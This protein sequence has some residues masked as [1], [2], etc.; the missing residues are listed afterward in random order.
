MQA[1][2]GGSHVDMD[3]RE[4]G[5]PGKPR[6]SA[7]QPHVG[8][9]LS[10]FFLTCAVYFLLWSPEN[11]PSWVGALIKCLPVL[12][13]VV[14]LW[15]VYPGGSYSLLLQGALLCSAV[16]DSCLVWP[17]AFLHG[18]AAFAVAHLLY[19]WAFGLTPLKPGLLLPLLLASIPYYGLLLWHLPP[20]M[21]LPLTAYSLVLAV[22]LWRGLARGGS[23]CWGALLFTLSDA[24]LAWNLFVHPLPHAHLVVMATYYAAQVLIALSA[25]QS[26][27]LKSN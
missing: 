25:F 4:E 18:M 19:L 14:F 1:T 27:R 8:R 20:D 22:M 13:L 9:W 15:T 7:Q 24:V 17:E 12:Y 26:P 16:G 6:F 23:T 2:L 3:T 11:Q 10:P 5:L 21:V